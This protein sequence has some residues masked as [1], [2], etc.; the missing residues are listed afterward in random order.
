MAE[1]EYTYRMHPQ[2]IM[3]GYDK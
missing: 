3:Q 2:W 1:L